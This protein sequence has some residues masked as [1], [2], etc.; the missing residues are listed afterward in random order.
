MTQ[1][2]LDSKFASF[3]ES[4]KPVLQVA[5]DY[6][7][8]E[9]A[10]K[11]VS[12]LRAELGAVF[13]A[14]V[15]TPL[16]KSEGMRAVSV[17]KSVVEPAPVLADTK[18]A[19]V[20]WLEA[21]LA[22]EHGAS[23][24]TVLGCTYNETIVGMIEEAG[25]H[26]I[27]VVADL[28]GVSDIAKRVEELWSLGVKAVELHVGIDVQQRLGMTVANLAEVVRVV[29]RRFPGILAVAGGLNAKT[30]PRVV[31]A[32]ADIVV[33]GSAIVKSSDPVGS[34]REILQK[35]GKLR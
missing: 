21:R 3:V 26:G 33:V 32:G 35:L 30:V 2:G 29:R 15:G 5:L 23:A 17:I 34:A 1:D 13:I 22:A 28:I 19:D 10:T 25:K 8:L 16:I 4:N 9:D 7:R 24:V 11:L 6:T 31:E 18:T 12:F 27:T 20:G 14:E